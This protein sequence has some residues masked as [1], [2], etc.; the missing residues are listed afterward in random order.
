MKATMK[1]L[2][3]ATFIAILVLAGN[4]KAE[5]TETKVTNNASIENTLQIENW[6]TDETIWNTNSIRM[7]YF[8]QET[9]ASME[10]E[11]WMTSEETWN[12]NNN[13]AEETETGLELEDWMFDNRTWE[14]AKKE[15][16]EAL[17]VEAWMINNKLWE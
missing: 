9:E 3:A 7:E 2:T 10:L 1:Q 16:E 15:V 14:T 8:V 13:F 4:A 11:N 6:M 5:G 17:K 12:F